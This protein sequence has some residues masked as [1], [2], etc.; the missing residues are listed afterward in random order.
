M[1]RV[2]AVL[3]PGVPALLPWYASQGDPVADL[4]AAARA[5]VGELLAPAPERVLVVT[6]AVTADAAARGVKA[7]VGL[8]VARHLLAE[9]GRADEPL[10]G[11][12]ATPRPSDAVLLVASGSARRSEKA[13][14][15]LDGRAF[16][17]DAGLARTVREGAPPP[18]DEALAEELWCFD[19][20][21]FRRLHELVD[22][23]GEVRYADDP[24]GVAYWVA[25]WT[26]LRGVAT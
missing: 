18:E 24:Y 3:V 16:D 14:G 23:P 11:S 10:D 19:L 5:A 21:V 22:G 2:R 6:A 25:T 20:P 9:A 1:S 17:L 26:R 12:A 7:P 8:R 4:R 13:P 15:H